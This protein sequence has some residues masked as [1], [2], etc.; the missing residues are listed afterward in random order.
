VADAQGV[1]SPTN[2]TSLQS[3]TSFSKMSRLPTP[4]SLTV[5]RAFEHENLYSPVLAVTL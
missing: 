4:N 1:L 5:L 2:L 3:P